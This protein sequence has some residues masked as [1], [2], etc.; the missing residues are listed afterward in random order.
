MASIEQIRQK[1]PQYS[2]MSDG[3]L[4][5]GIHRKFY[6]NMHPRKFLNSIEGAANAHATIKNPELKTYFRERAVAPMKDETEMQAGARAGG[7]SYGPTETGGRLMSVVRS[8]LQGVSAGY[9]DEAVGQAYSLLSG[10]SPAFEQEKERRRVELGDE[11]YPVQSAL[12]EI[13]GALAMPAT[14]IKSIPA[15]IGLGTASGMAYASGKARPGERIDAAKDAAVPSAI[16]S[17]LAVPIQ[18]IAQKGVRAV[19]NSAQK[20]PTLGA[21][22]AARD[23]AYK[24][25]DESTFQ[26]S[27]D[28]Y[29]GV[30]TR[31][32]SDLAD[33]TGPYVKGASKKTDAALNIIERNWGD[34]IP[35]TKVDN[36]RKSLWKIWKSADDDEATSILRMIN[37]I[38]DMVDN[39]PGATPIVEAAREANKT[40][41]RVEFLQAEFDK[42]ARN[43]QVTGSGGNIYNNYARVFKNILNNPNKSRNFS[44]EQLAFMQK[45]I[46]T[47]IGDDM[48]RKLGKLSP[49][50][51]G[52]MLALNVI[53]GSIDPK[54]WAVGGL[55]G[56]AKALSDRAMGNKVDDVLSIAAGAP[57]RIPGSTPSNFPG[58][59][60]IGGLLA[61]EN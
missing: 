3:D 51:N 25:V 59:A 56:A 23:T 8:G 9:G 32:Y 17:A 38:D 6:P 18:R 50:G 37:A 30:L 5:M 57:V 53:G 54:L 14:A 31:I 60:A 10:N 27:A 24:A 11:T 20:R 52:L 46:D 4:L 12:S 2:D 42:A 13:G 35:L 34:G 21:L 48:L 22:K 40:F 44:G 29:D 36:I 61:T 49:D 33:P 19:F 28:D 7:T 45:A 26:F 1:Y 16:F 41:K 47:N 43:T 55:G 58:A 15:A 39:A